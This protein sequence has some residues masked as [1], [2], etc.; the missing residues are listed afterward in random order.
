MIRHILLIQF[1]EGIEPSE[2]EIIKK[3]F[4]EIPTKIEGI[5]SV[6]WGDNDSP[7]NL[8]Q[9]YTHCVMMN[10]K[11]ESSRKNYLYHPQHDA[12]KAV[13]LPFLKDIIVM[14]YT[15]NNQP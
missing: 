10:F 5:L 7:E 1:I 9:N 8:N 2:I 12:L 13:F 11:D 3:R 14:D 6:E 4:M 15:V